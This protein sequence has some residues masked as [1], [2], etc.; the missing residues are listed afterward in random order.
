M[1]A[2]QEVHQWPD[3]NASKLPIERLSENIVLPAPSMQGLSQAGS[4]VQHRGHATHLL[5]LKRDCWGW[6]VHGVEKPNRGAK[7]Y[8]VPYMQADW[9]GSWGAECS[10]HGL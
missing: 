8:V 5:L 10:S 4:R 6:C 2:E 1:G 9:S 7:T 3:H